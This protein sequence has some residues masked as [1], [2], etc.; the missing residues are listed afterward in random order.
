MRAEPAGS[1]DRLDVMC[2]RK[3]ALA[4]L[5]S[6]ENAGPWTEDCGSIS[7]KDTYSVADLTPGPG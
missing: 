6:S 1:P 3:E 4:S 2:N 7:V 5:L